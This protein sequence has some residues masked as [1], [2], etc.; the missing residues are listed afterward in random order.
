M[1][2]FLTHENAG[3][4]SGTFAPLP[5]HSTHFGIDSCAYRSGRRKGERL[6]SPHRRQDCVYVHSH[7]ISMRAK[8]GRAH[9]ANPKHSE[10]IKRSMAESR[11]T[12]L[13]MMLQETDS[14]KAHTKWGCT[15]CSWSL[16]ADHGRPD[17][18]TR[19]DAVSAFESHT[20]GD[21]EPKPQTL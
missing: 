16:K 3:L 10:E 11:M 2:L 7:L 19:K 18:P 6:T 1:A 4:D 8:P 17:Q 12:E 14:G 13:R 21:F 20:C 9:K 15:R 5:T